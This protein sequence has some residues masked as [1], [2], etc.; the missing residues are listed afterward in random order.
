MSK[1]NIKAEANEFDEAIEASK[2][3]VEKNIKPLGY[4]IGAVLVV[5]I[6]ILLVHQFYIVPNNK[7]ADE[8]LFAAQQQFMDGNYEKALNGDG[9]SGCCRQVWQ[10]QGWQSGHSVCR[11][12]LCSDR[13]V[14]RGCE[15]AG[16]L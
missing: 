5:V 2:S 4:G 16:G 1:K 8:A 13:E 3:F 6:G 7:K 14:R 9:L 12:V 10:H 15:D 11:Y